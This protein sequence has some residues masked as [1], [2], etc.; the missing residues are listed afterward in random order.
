VKKTLIL[1]PHF[2]TKG[3]IANYYNLLSK[4]L[5]ESFSFLTRGARK[6][7]FTGPKL[8]LTLLYFWDYIRF[9]HYLL[10]KKTDVVLINTSLGLTG[11]YRDAI[12][13]LISKLFKKEV[14]TYFRGLDINIQKQIHSK[15]KTIFKIFYK[16]DK[17]ISLSGSFNELLKLNGY[18]GK[19]FR[20]NT[21][22]DNNIVNW[23]TQKNFKELKIKILFLARV[24]KEKGI[25]E[26]IHAFEMLYNRRKNVELNIVGDGMFLANA[27]EYVEHNNL[28]SINFKGYLQGNEKYDQYKSNHIYILPSYSE[29]LPNSLL[30][31]MAFGFPSV[32]TEVGGIPDVFTNILNGKLIKSPPKTEDIIEAL[33]CLIE[34]PDELE[35][36]SKRNHKYAVDNFLAN[37][38]A[39]RLNEIINE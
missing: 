4:Y 1:S 36:I 9:I 18:N 16:S 28:N 22:I 12:F 24:E 8:F 23:F 39:K 5:D 2:E 35:I 37:N 11:L 26:L 15:Y 31:A 7:P 29:G 20:E 32:V 17:I 34:D 33:D 30:E 25:M 27:K 21:L 6:Q 19:I 13:I 14:I 10:T 38:V 3:G